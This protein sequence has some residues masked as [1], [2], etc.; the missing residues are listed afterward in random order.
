MSV[1]G[2]RRRRQLWRG[3]LVRAGARRF[4]ATGSLRRWLWAAVLEWRWPHGGPGK[5]CC[6]AIRFVVERQPPARRAEPTTT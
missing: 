6:G 5:G 3:G 2:C 4:A 1:A